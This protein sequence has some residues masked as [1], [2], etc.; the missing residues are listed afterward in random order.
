MTHLSSPLDQ[1]IS[2]SPDEAEPA[3]E[4]GGYRHKNDVSPPKS[5]AK[6]LL[7]HAGAWEGEDLEELLAEVYALRGRSQF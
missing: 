4:N 1:P 2:G 6:A 5:S 3:V 7:Q